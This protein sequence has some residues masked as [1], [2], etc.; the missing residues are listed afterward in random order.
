MAN[1][2]KVFHWQS[3]FKVVSRRA[4]ERIETHNLQFPT[5]AEQARDK[6]QMP[7]IVERDTFSLAYPRRIKESEEKTILN[8]LKQWCKQSADKINAGER[9]LNNLVFTNRKSARNFKRSARGSNHHFAKGVYCGCLIGEVDEQTIEY[10]CQFTY[11]DGKGVGVR[12]WK[13]FH[14]TNQDFELCIHLDLIPL[15][16]LPED[17]ELLVFDPYADSPEARYIPPHKPNLPSNGGPQGHFHG[18]I[19]YTSKM[20]LAGIHFEGDGA[21]CEGMSKQQKM[22]P[23]PDQIETFNKEISQPSDDDEGN[24]KEVTGSFMRLYLDGQVLKAY[25]RLLIDAY[26]QKLG[27]AMERSFSPTELERG[28]KAAYDLLKACDLDALDGFVD[29]CLRT[30][31]HMEQ[32]ILH[33][34]ARNFVMP[35]SKWFDIHYSHN[36]AGAYRK[37]LLPWEHTAKQWQSD[38]TTSVSH[39]VK[40]GN[41]YERLAEMLQKHLAHLHSSDSRIKQAKLDKWAH[42]L[43]LLHKESKLS[44]QEIQSLIIWLIKSPSKRAQFW[45]K[46]SGGFG[47]RSASGLRRNFSQIHAQMKY[48]QSYRKS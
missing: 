43:R 21:S 31:T 19:C 47:I 20:G 17:V 13:R 26:K 14:G 4:Y 8:V 29:K 44:L 11:A 33:D 2:N 40:P 37:F 23:F 9:Q 39:V 46:E 18:N 32:W 30:I 22:P 25:S 16:M 24:S 15:H 10:K 28:R 7:E 41:E 35:P 48:E 27:T 6:K 34:P 36:I 38:I 45:R 12:P 1:R 3:L 42:H 5:P